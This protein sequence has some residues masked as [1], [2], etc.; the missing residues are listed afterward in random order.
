MSEA[1]TGRD[2]VREKINAL[3]KRIPS[4]YHDDRIT[5]DRTVIESGSVQH[6]RK[7]FGKPD[8]VFNSHGAPDR[9]AAEAL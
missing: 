9:E 2:F 1:P 3:A 5:S 7:S 4:L 6:F 8:K